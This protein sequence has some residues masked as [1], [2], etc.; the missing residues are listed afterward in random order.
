MTI[1][2]AMKKYRLPNPTTQE[3]LECNWKTVLRFGDKVLLAGYCYNGA[4][5]HCYYG[6]VYEFL[7]SDHSVEGTLGLY[8][9]S[10]IMF[11]D[12]GSAIAWAMQQ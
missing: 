3:D 6:A 9:A 12:D 4:N 1:S 2:E 10:D 11:E 5:N 7:G 8:T